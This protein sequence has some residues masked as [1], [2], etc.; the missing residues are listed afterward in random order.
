VESCDPT[1]TCDHDQWMFKGVFFEHLGYFLADIVGSCDL[2]LS[3]TLVQKYSKFIYANAQAV[4]DIS[5]GSNGQVGNWWAG[6]PGHQQFS[7]ETTGSGVAAV[8][9]AVR[10]DQWL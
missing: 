4:W 10:V 2:N 5:T 1:L 7:V 3:T 8:C 9:C 6:S